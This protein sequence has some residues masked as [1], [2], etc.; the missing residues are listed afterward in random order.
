ML[1]SADQ[2]QTI[3]NLKIKHKYTGDA[4][5]ERLSDLLL[6]RNEEAHFLVKDIAPL[7][8]KAAMAIHMQAMD[9][10]TGKKV[11][12]PERRAVI[13]AIDL[14]LIAANEGELE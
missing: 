11:I 3:Q 5:P 12:S 13:I 1:W 8:R 2:L 10:I 14:F 6:H 7:A 9:P 4:L